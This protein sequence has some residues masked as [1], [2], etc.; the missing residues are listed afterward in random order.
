MLDKNDYIE[1]YI[2][3]HIGIILFLFFSFLFSKCNFIF[4]PKEFPGDATKTW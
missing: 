2:K 4:S 3:K 1:K